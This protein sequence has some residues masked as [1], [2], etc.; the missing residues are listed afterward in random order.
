M[1]MN[2]NMMDDNFAMDDF[3]ME[4]GGES[5]EQEAQ[6]WEPEEF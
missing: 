6:L 1:E 5:Q 2:Y 3:W 4:Y